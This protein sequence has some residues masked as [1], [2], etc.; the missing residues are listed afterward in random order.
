MDSNAIFNVIKFSLI[1]S[2]INID[3]KNVVSIGLSRPI[4]IGPILGYLIGNL[5]YGIFVG[6]I[7][8]LILINLVPV[9]AFIPPNGAIITGVVMILSH[10]FHIY[11]TGTLLPVILIYAI[12]WGHV[13][14]RITRLL[15][16]K[17]TFLVEKF[18]KEVQHLKF[19]F[20]LYNLAALLIDCIAYFIIVF[21]GSSL[22]IILFKKLIPELFSLIFLFEKTLYYLPLFSL[23]YVLNSFD[24]PKKIYFLLLGIILALLLSF[25]TSSPLLIITITGFF[26]YIILYS[27]HFYREHYYEI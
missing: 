12:F 14:K 15:W 20:F 4:I 1:V 6:C 19:N 17:N 9:G 2:V 10:Y 27:V 5:Y 11:K 21:I 25:I 26:S 22:G 16:L 3:D 13:S 18:L 23:L 7:L 24:I 8:E